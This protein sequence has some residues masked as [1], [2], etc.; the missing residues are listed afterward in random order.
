MILVARNEAPLQDLRS[1][2]PARVQVVAADL[3]K[4]EIARGTIDTALK[5]FGQIDGLVINHGTLEP[6]TR[7]ATSDPKAWRSSFDI[8]F[9]SAV[10]WACY[11][12]KGL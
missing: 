9:F 2:Y 11:L 8:N 1:K 6:V 4:L 12:P 3:G 5:E 7:V 10:E